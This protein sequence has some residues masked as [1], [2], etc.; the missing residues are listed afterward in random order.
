MVEGGLAMQSLS[1][2]FFINLADMDGRGGQRG[3]STR[4]V[5]T[6][7]ST[8]TRCI[9]SSWVVQVVVV[10]QIWLVQVGSSKD[11]D[12]EDDT[13]DKIA[14]Q[15]ATSRCDVGNI[16]RDSCEYIEL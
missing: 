10:G 4:V 7:W 14:S 6:S 9:I 15:G 13:R 8:V 2:T 12:P 16:K 3:V 1:V 11:N 5:S